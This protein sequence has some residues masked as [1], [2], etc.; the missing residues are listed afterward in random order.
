[1]RTEL[2]WHSKAKYAEKVG[3]PQK[4]ATETR[5]QCSRQAALLQALPLLHGE[6]MPTKDEGVAVRARRT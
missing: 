4:E 6:K 1:M 3:S 5:S 2:V